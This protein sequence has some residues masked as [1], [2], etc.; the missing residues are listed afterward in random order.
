MPGTYK[1][2]RLRADAKSRLLS[3]G[4]GRITPT[5]YEEE[6]AENRHGSR[7]GS[8]AGVEQGKTLFV[9]SANAAAACLASDNSAAEPTLRTGALA[10]RVITS[11]QR[12]DMNTAR[13]ALQSALAR[14]GSR[15]ALGRLVATSAHV[16]LSRAWD[17]LGNS[18]KAK[19]QKDAAVD[20]SPPAFGAWLQMIEAPLREKT[21]HALTIPELYRSRKGKVSDKWSSYLPRYQEMFSRYREL[22]INILEIGVQNGGSLEVWSEYFPNARYIVG[23]DIDPACAALEF[24]DRRIKVVVGDANDP[25][26]L[27]GILQISSEYNIIIDDGAHTSESIKKAFGN[28][29]PLLAF[30]GLYVVED[31]HCS[32][33]PEYGGGLKDPD[34][35]HELFKVISDFVNS[36]HWRVNEEDGL[37]LL[38]QDCSWD[39]SSM[40][41]LLSFVNSISFCNSMVIIAKERVHRNVLGRRLARGC[42]AKVWA[43]IFEAIPVV[44]GKS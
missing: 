25:A 4:K 26:T 17:N 14:G 12:G 2:R 6:N 39:F 35:A 33:W 19:A 5:G 37:A 23:C 43:G 24:D 31:L 36:E 22:P 32:Y 3:K 11:L 8:Q 29:F 15:K 21:P 30:N 27:K 13:R 41:E 9:E 34:S 10:I 20:A 1:R 38:S 16:S 44:S 40:G 28:Y 7:P 42:I 18:T